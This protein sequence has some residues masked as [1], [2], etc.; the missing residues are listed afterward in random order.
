M[1]YIEHRFI[2]D[3]QEASHHFIGT[4]GVNNHLDII[5]I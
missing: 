4:R 5:L 3:V 2:T 1:D